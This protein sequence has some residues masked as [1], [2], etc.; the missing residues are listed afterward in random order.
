MPIKYLKQSILFFFVK[1]L[2]KRKFCL[3]F[4]YVNIGDLNLVANITT[5]TSIKSQISKEIPRQ[6]ETMV[7][8]KAEH[9]FN[10]IDS[11]TSCSTIANSVIKIIKQIYSIYQNVKANKHQCKRLQDRLTIIQIPIE[12]LN[13]LLKEQLEKYKKTK[14]CDIDIIQVQN[15]REILQNIEGLVKHSENVINDWSHMGDSF[16]GKLKQAFT[17]GKFGQE[18]EQITKKLKELLDDLK[19]NLIIQNFIKLNVQASNWENED[20]E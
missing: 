6:I 15:I 13:E 12:K 17:S 14:K 1:I 8:D 9:A 18:F 10:I 19:T 2:R 5:V 3:I 11:I 7:I 4:I 20:K 16:F